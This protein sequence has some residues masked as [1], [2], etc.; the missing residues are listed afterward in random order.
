[1]PLAPGR[2]PEA[3]ERADVLA[4]RDAGHEKGNDPEK[5]KTNQKQATGG[6]LLFGN[7]WVHSRIAY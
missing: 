4:A 1:M 7:F 5:K 6:F 3:R 2:L